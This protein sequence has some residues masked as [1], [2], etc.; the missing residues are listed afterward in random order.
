MLTNGR[1]TPKGSFFDNRSIIANWD[2]T[3]DFVEVII[4]VLIA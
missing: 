1:C 3:S 2:N 4:G